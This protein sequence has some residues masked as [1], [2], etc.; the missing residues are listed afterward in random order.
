MA[1][2]RN[3]TW[4]EIAVHYGG[5]RNAIRALGW[6]SSWMHV[7]I[8]L[9]RDPS[10]EEV[11][12]WW[13]MS[14]RSA[15]RNQAAFRTCFPRTDSPEAI[16]ENNPDALAKIEKSARAL[17]DLEA[18]VRARRAAKDTDILNTGLLPGAG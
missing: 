6:A 13:G 18:S 17:Q 3:P 4:I 10:V 14:R 5:F 2:K 1:A 9:G 15:F 8:V 7:K 11:A 16:Y 12:E